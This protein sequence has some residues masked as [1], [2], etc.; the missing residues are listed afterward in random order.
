ML[1]PCSGE[2]INLWIGSIEPVSK[3]IMA[4]FIAVPCRKFKLT[5]RQ[6]IW[7]LLLNRFHYPPSRGFSLAWLLAFTKS[8]AWLVVLRCGF[9]YARWNKPT[10]RQRGFA[11][12]F[13]N[14]KSNAREKP[15]LARYCCTWTCV[16]N[17]FKPRPQNEIPLVSVAKKSPETCAR[18]QSVQISPHGG[19]WQ[20]NLLQE[21][22]PRERGT[23][24][25]NN[26]MKM[27]HLLNPRSMTSTRCWVSWIIRTETSI[28]W[29]VRWRPRANSWC[30]CA[31][32]LEGSFKN[33]IL[34]EQPP[35]KQRLEAREGIYSIPRRRS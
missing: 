27:T 7:L 1:H 4:I 23:P 2:R 14:A 34:L 3:S 22:S 5:Q 13:V 6:L 9:V 19:P 15:L 32:A 8:F 24:R 31:A 10:T 30:L 29:Q 12:D 20:I 35:R 17:V 25:Q 28:A 26:S 21:P 16:W 33:F 11:N 18:N